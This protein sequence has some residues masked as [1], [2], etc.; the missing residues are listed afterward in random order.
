MLPLPGR[1]EPSVPRRAST[2]FAAAC[3]PK[4]Q[5][6]LWLHLRWLRCTYTSLSLRAASRTNTLACI[7]KPLK[8]APYLERRGRH[9]SRA[10][11]PRPAA[12]VVG[13][14]AKATSQCALRPRRGTPKRT[15]HPN[16]RDAAVIAAVLGSGR[17][18]R[19]GMHGTGPTA[20]LGCMHAGLDAHQAGRSIYWP[21]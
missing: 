20:G 2:A 12:P 6:L 17:P 4:P 21:P 1:L 19:W 3:H 8:R 13:A 7:R 14:P 9:A 10:C 11:S 15:R 5:R 16:V 18:N